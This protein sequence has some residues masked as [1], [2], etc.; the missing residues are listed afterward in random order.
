MDT[1]SQL[2]PR[3]LESPVGVDILTNSIRFGRPSSTRAE[4][5]ITYLADSL[6][7]RSPLLDRR[8]AEHEAKE[9]AAGVVVQNP[10]LASSSVSFQ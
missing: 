5:A 1:M 6:S 4:G 7:E 2:E 9:T 10:K 8:G 3:R